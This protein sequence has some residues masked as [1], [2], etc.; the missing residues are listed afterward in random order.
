MILARQWLEVLLAS[1]ANGSSG[2]WIS[3]LVITD[4]AS[5]SILQVF[6]RQIHA[7][8]VTQKAFDL[9]CELNPQLLKDLT[10]LSV[11][12]PLISSFFMFRPTYQGPFRGKLEKAMEGL[13]ATPGGK[14]ILAIFKSSRLEK[15]PS[16]ILEPTRYFILEYQSL[17]NKGT[18]P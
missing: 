3:K 13:H 1:I 10:R 5:K 7:A 14:Q 15:L 16:S 12:P 11:S 17:V 6:F 2:S 4:N 9:A 18:Q 8:L